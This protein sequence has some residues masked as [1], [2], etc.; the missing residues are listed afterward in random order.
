MLYSVQL[1]TASHKYHSSSALNHHISNY[2]STQHNSKEHL[3]I[4]RLLQFSQTG[5]NLQFSSPYS[6]WVTTYTSC[7]SLRFTPPGS[8]NCL[9]IAD[10]PRRLEPSPKP[11]QKVRASRPL[12]KQEISTGK[13]PLCRT[14]L[15][16]QLP[17]C[18]PGRLHSSLFFK[19]KVFVLESY[20]W[21]KQPFPSLSFFKIVFHPD[22]EWKYFLKTRPFSHV[23]KGFPFS[24]KVYTQGLKQNRWCQ[25]L[26]AF[27]MIVL[28]WQSCSLLKLKDLNEI[29]GT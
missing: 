4:S 23:K 17:I 26:R 14:V 29:M 8:K 18:L 9:L 13:F 15:C 25:S 1:C 2:T 28:W 16:R 27:G 21:E 5:L 7:Y 22:A 24:G 6:L 11:V 12:R 10:L 3:C 20:T 19:N